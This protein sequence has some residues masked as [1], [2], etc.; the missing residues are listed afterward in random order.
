MN[1]KVLVARAKCAMPRSVS[2]GVALCDATVLRSGLLQ[3]DTVS[4][5]HRPVESD[6]GT[7]IGVDAAR[8]V[9]TQVRLPSLIPIIVTEAGSQ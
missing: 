4:E 7:P 3:Q 6:S 9:R 1:W 2:R 5:A 8:G